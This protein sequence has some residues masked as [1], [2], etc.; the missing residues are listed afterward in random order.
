MD[1]NYNKPYPYDQSYDKHSYYKK[2]SYYDKS[3]YYDNTYNQKYNK[4][5]GIKAYKIVFCLNHIG[6]FLVTN[7]L[8]KVA[9]M[10]VDF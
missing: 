8:T 2:P 10:Y 6:Q 3:S 9:Q 4:P 7:C 5:R 1:Y